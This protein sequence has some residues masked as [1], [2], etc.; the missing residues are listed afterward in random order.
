MI[1][2]LIHFSVYN[3]GVVF[4]L[5]ALLAVLGWFSFQSLPID[6][7]PDI[8]NNQVQ[9]NASVEG[10]TPEEIER[11][12]TVPIENG[13]GGLS[14]LVQTRSI[15]RF[16]LSQVTLVFEEDVDVYRA[17]QLVAER[18]QQVS[19]ELPPNIQP[20]LGPITTG[21]GD[22]FFYTVQAKTPAMGPERAKQ[23]ME[24]RSLHDWFIKP[25]L[26]TVKGVAEVNAIGGFEKQFHIQPNPARMARYGLHFGDLIEA[27]EK[28]NRNVGGGYVQQTSE[29]FLVQATGLLKNEEDIRQVPVKSL[30]TL[31]TLRIGDVAN[32]QLAT[33][34]RTGAALVNG[35]EDLLGTAM[36]R[37]GENSREV[38][39]RVAQK[40]EEL[41]KD[42]PP[43]VV[44]TTLYDRSDLVDATL[45]T[46]EHNLVTG[47]VLVIVILMLLLGN[48]RAA[49]ITAVTI[50][51]TLL[52]TFIVMK[53][54]GMSGN[55]MSLGALD[56]GII[57]DGVVIV[58]DNCVRRIHVR[59]QELGRKLSIDELNA[60]VM[61]AAVE[62]R[63]SAG[64][65]E[66][67]I[68]VVL[69]PIFAFTG[70]EGKMFIPMVGTFVIAVLSALL[71]SFTLAPAL[72]S[73]FLRGH[74]ADKE[75]WLMRKI[76]S[77]YDK[78][79][80]SVLGHS[81]WV[82]AVGALSVLVGGVLFSRLGGEFLPQL[83]EGS[84][85]IQFFRPATISID[86]AVALQEKSEKIIRRFPEV[87]N[88]FSR[89]GTAEIATDPMPISISDTFIMLHERKTWPLVEGR[90]P[91]KGE[92]AQ[93]I[94]A[95]LQ[96]EIP[97]QR[98]LLTQPI[99]MRFNE[100]L[101]GTRADIAVKVFGD[102][103]EQLT[104]IA[105]N[106]KSSIEKV[107]G[108]GDVELELQGKTPLLHVE[109]K[110]GELRALGLANQEVLETVGV[111]VGGEEAGSI[112]EGFRRY[113]IVVRLQEKDRSNLDALKSLPVGLGTNATVPL[114]EVAN[115][116]FED[117]YGTIAREQSKRRVSIMVN[118]R[119]R[120]TESFVNE[121]QEVSAQ[122]VKMPAGYFA[123]WG[124]N[125]KNLQ[126]AKKRLSIMTPLVLVLVLFMI[127]AAFRSVFETLLVFSCVPLALVG[128]V[129]GLILNDLPFS[130]S[131]GVGF[132][133]LSGIAVLNGVVLINVF[134]DLR[135]KGIKGHDLIHQGTE[136]RIR[137]VL[138]TALV[139]IFGFLPMMLST[140]MGSE[141]QRPLASVVIGGVISSTLLTL[142]VLPSLV[143]L[144]EKRIWKAK[145]VEL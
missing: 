60:T 37:L 67:I 38:A 104:Q 55:L 12:I 88:V 48:I 18:L 130:I 79:L 68:V 77:G 97:G 9:I 113:P 112:Y 109:P 22:I 92:L 103:M 28:T 141:V 45:N 106:L 63:Q 36:M 72:A 83:D 78:S 84:L 134:N 145:E 53:K 121:A 56:F 128:G 50:P 35:Q 126:E 27:M 13:M 115:L 31:K 124:G 34:L 4:A 100:L 40:V 143:A 2:R 17:R 89:L 39:H 54:L 137:P 46:V 66:L 58:I 29:Q 44:L 65:G 120:D 42:L 1:Q 71:L 61:D 15:S 99:Q 123:E 144:L 24:L 111:A 136:M 125:F 108:A 21:L 5:A 101:E 70:I 85:V 129:L 122:A 52:M 102:D 11:Y 73:L 69:L 62:I 59:A 114:S 117:T 23:L 43:D 20:K 116:H 16:G 25:R 94:A 131:A 74:V 30:E 110:L 87:S 81:R 82:I 132:V 10:L 140:G 139:E 7:V 51:L 64:F 93:R 47:A 75:P 3:K 57:I 6:A 105:Q 142:F 133:A 98:L 14:G 138:M 135:E 127:F 118:P 80:R 26:L 91:L 19:T 95:E 76:K 8:T 90:R 41:K 32:V 33:E 49:I 96:A 119:G 107:P 86:Q